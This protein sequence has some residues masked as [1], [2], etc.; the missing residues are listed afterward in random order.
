MN[1]KIYI[2]PAT[3]VTN[4]TTTNNDYNYNNNDSDYD[5]DGLVQL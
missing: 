1:A 5:D 2:R 3:S 4:P